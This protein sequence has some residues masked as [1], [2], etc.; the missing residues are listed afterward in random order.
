MLR[1]LDDGRL[2]IDNT[3]CERGMRTIACGRKNYLFAG[4]DEGAERAATMYTITETCK[5][6][7]VNPWAYLKDVLWKLQV[8]MWPKSRLDELLPP[9]W[10]E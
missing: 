10:A 5:R 9:N 2:P 4:S 8:D 3:D 6:T 7:G 1:F